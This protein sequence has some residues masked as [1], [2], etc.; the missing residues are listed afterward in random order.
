MSNDYEIEEYF[1]DAVVDGNLNRVKH[2]IENLN[3]NPTYD[4]NL[5]M[6]IISEEGIDSLFDY[7][8][9][10]N[11]IDL[12]WNNFDLLISAAKFEHPIICKKIILNSS[13]IDKINNAWLETHI[14][15]NKAKNLIKY[16]IKVRDF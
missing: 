4:D 5:A 9:T 13:K 3:I 12:S 15:E 8:I 7:F 6:R 14:K 10:L 1:I 16:L 11:E 2:Y